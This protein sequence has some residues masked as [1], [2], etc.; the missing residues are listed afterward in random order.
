MNFLKNLSLKG[1]ILLIMIIPLVAYL[2][3]AGTNLFNS[4]NQLKSY[5]NIHTL[6]VLSS[7]ISSLVHELQKERGMSA[8][9]LSDKG[10]KFKTKLYTQRLNTD[11]RRKLLADVLANF[12]FKEFNQNLKERMDHALTNV[13]NIESERQAISS[14]QRTT[15]EA[16]TFYTSTNT[17]LL[18]IIGYLTHLSTNAELTSEISAYYN[19]LQSKERAGKERAVMS[20]VFSRGS[21]TAETYATFVQLITE[22]NTFLSVFKTFAGT[23]EK[24]FFNST[25]SGSVVDEVERMRQVALGVNLDTTK[26]FGVDPVVWFDTI[27]KKINLLKKV[28]DY[29][30]EDLQEHAE[31]LAKTQKRVMVISLIIFSTIVALCFFLAYFVSSLILNGVKQATAVAL[32]L[33][34]GKGDLSK[35]INLQTTDEIGQLSQSVDKML[36]NLSSMIGQIQHI[37]GSLDSSNRELFKLSLEMTEETENVAG[38]ASTVSAAAEEMSV[39]METVSLAV[40]EATQNVASVAAATEEIASISQEISASTEKA[41]NITSKAVAQ[42]ASSSKKVD[43]LGHAA[44]EIGKVTET[45]TEISEQTNL[46][47]LNATIEAARAGEAGKGF[48]VVANEIKDLANQTAEATFEIKTRIETIQSSTRGTVSEIEEISSVIDEINEIVTGISSSVETQTATT[49]EISGNINQTAQGIQEVTENVSQAS[50]VSREVAQDI[51][52]V[53]QS[54]SQILNSSKNVNGNAG[55]LSK[56]AEQLQGLVGKF[57]V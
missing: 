9:F 52:I 11:K 10:E 13:A 50:T 29:F 45:I 55:E 2:M 15:K 36:N 20:G 5:N 33:A 47:A 35:R 6:S 31:R 51:A 23:A 53:D 30:S 42:A 14:K 16:V 17:G 12:D 18:D 46:L 41:R 26:G 32:E 7:N 34:E 48:A 25:V 39:N 49:T 8:G 38:R 28:E 22:Q 57:K 56:L 1:K 4:Y 3:V 40:E 21:F 19:F 27:T 44:N 37:S 54:S 43:E 24:K